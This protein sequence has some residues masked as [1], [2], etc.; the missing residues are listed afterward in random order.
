MDL[1]TKQKTEN[2]EELLQN[3]D[4]QN[5]KL[6]K[7]ID[8]PL[9]LSKEFLQTINN[10]EILQKE[11]KQKQ[12]IVEEQDKLIKNKLQ[13]LT[14]F[15][16]IKINQKEHIN[17]EEK[18]SRYTKALNFTVK[19]IEN[20]I[21]YCKTLKTL[22]FIIVDK[23]APNSFAKCIQNK[24]KQLK[25]YTKLIRKDFMVSFSQYNF[26][27]LSQIKN[28]SYLITFLKI[29]KKSSSTSSH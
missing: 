10:L 23:Q 7:V 9:S 27:S 2:F 28:L 11:I 13:K 3:L 18:T 25:R 15:K 21:N 14:N 26:E 8:L 17:K 19:E 29:Q 4:Q 16:N 6:V 20:E 12:K 1:E 22:S 24:T 5:K